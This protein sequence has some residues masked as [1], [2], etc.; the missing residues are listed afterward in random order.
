MNRERREVVRFLEKRGW[1][2]LNGSTEDEEG[3]T[4]IQEERGIQ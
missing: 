1:R 2:I 3:N 4:L